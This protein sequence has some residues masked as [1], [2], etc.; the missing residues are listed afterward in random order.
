DELFAPRN[1]A[2]TAVLMGRSTNASKPTTVVSRASKGDIKARFSFNG[3]RFDSLFHVLK[4]AEAGCN[5]VFELFAEAKPNHPNVV[6]LVGPEVI[7]N[8]TFIDT[9]KA[10]F[11]HPDVKDS[12][13]PK[14]VK[15]WLDETLLEKKKRGED[16][17]KSK[18]CSWWLKNRAEVA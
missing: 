3:D 8:G 12:E 5:D 1:K 11:I 10:L 13:I 4:G 14:D 15:N 7:K 6:S 17:P 2:L 16:S 18:A 9:R